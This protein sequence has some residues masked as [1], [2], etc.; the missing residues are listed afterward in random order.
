LSGQV[1]QGRRGMRLTLGSG[2]EGAEIEQDVKVVHFL[3]CVG[4]IAHRPHLEARVVNRRSACRVLLSLLMVLWTAPIVAAQAQIDASGTWTWTQQG[5]GG[6][7]GPADS[8][9]GGG[10]AGRAP[11]PPPGGGGGGGGG[12]GRR[13]GAPVEIILTLKQDGEKLT[14]SATGLN[15]QDPAAKVDIKDGSVKGST[16]MFKITRTTQRGEITTTYT[17]RLDGDT[18]TGTS[19]TEFNGHPISREWTPTRQKT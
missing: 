18:I 17:G 19:E 13:G 1:G 16:V 5:F 3:A 11:T 10:G 6:R 14:G 4:L 2:E 9:G 15:F 12:G 7:R 8:G